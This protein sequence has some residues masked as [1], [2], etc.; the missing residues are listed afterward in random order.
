MGMF[1]DIMYNAE[2]K[3]EF[4]GWLL[5]YALGSLLSWTL[6]NVI[7]MIALNAFCAVFLGLF[8]V[9]TDDFA[10]GIGYQGPDFLPCGLFCWGVFTIIMIIEGNKSYNKYK[11]KQKQ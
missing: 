11:S 2:V 3:S 8:V 10:L 5:F 1:K 7:F 6:F 9:A 4:K